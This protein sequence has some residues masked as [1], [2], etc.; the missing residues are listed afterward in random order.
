MWV[1]IFGEKKVFFSRF[2]SDL[3]HANGRYL[4]DDLFDH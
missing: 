2:F 1:E 3:R 4:V